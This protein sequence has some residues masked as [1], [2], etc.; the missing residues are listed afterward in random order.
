MTDKHIETERKYIIEMPDVALLQ[1]EKGY[2][3]SE[4]VQIYL[5]SEPHVTRRVRSRTS[6]GG[7]VYTETKKIRISK[8]SAIEDER[9][10]SELEFSELLK[11]VRCGSSPIKKVRHA[12]SYCDGAFE[13]DVYPYWKRTA[14]LETELPSETTVIKMPPYVKILREVTGERE[15]TNSAMANSFPKEII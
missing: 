14:I 15:Y 12:F 8:M 13:I 10:I 2:F 4:I 7:T 5:E 1:K 6:E 9:E 3:K 11:K